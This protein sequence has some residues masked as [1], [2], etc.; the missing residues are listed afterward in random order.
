MG[1]NHIG[2]RQY[3]SLTGLPRLLGDCTTQ[4]AALELQL[5][6]TG[7]CGRIAWGGHRLLGWHN[8]AWLWHAFMISQLLLLASQ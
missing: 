3:H 8:V 4:E 7:G 2:L 6:S 1:M 5:V